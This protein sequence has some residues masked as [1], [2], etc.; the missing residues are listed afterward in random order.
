MTPQAHI[1]ALKALH[2]AVGIESNK[3]AGVLSTNR[4]IISESHA[5]NNTQWAGR[6]P[7]GGLGFTDPT[8]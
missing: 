6:M 5:H 1:A 3:L 7:V 4:L 2:V 8:S